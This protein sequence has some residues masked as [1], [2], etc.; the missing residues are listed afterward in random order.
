MLTASDETLLRMVKLKELTI[1]ADDVR[2]VRDT[3][4]RQVQAAYCRRVPEACP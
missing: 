4:G 1:T 3:R 2:T